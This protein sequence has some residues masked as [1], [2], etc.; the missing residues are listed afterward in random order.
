MGFFLQIMEILL[1]ITCGFSSSLEVLKK[2]GKKVIKKV[3]TNRCAFWASQ[4]KDLQFWVKQ[5]CTTFHFIFYFDTKWQY[6]NIFSI[7]LP[8]PFVSIF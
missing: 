1:E 2:V 5:I 7:L 4:E 3:H 6:M 8:E